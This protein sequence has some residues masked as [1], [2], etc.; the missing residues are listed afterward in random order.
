MDPAQEKAYKQM[1]ETS[2][3]ILEGGELNAIGVLAELTRLKQFSTVC[4]RME[5]GQFVPALPSNKFDYLVQM[6]EER[7]FNG[8]G[9]SCKIVVASQFTQTLELFRDEL[10]RTKTVNP[11]DL[12]MITGKV[13]GQ[14]RAEILKDFNRSVGQGPHLMLLNTKAG[15]VAIT[16]DSADEMVIL[17]ETWVADEQEQLEDRIHRVSNP[18]PVWYHYL[19][20]LHTIEEAIAMKNLEDDKASQ[21][22]LDGRRGIDYAVKLLSDARRLAGVKA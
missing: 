6:L 21:R 2:V 9:P 4:G 1:L 12:V 8:E 11:R 16:I 3:A 10:I 18:R 15:G 19:R 7:G 20:S 13:T 5:G 17:D 22:L 14:Q